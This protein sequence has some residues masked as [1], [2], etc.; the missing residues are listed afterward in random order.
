MFITK[1]PFCLKDRYCSHELTICALS[2]LGPFAEEDNSSVQQNISTD[3]DLSDIRI[4]AHGCKTHTHTI[5]HTEKNLVQCTN[6]SICVTQVMVVVEYPREWAHEK[7]NGAGK[8]KVGQ[9]LIVWRISNQS[10]DKQAP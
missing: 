5:T 3:R 7:L 10:A 6:R 4:R 2:A 8:A 9:S 1:I